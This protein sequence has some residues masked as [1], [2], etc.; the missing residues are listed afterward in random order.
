MRTLIFKTAIVKQL[1]FALLVMSPLFSQSFNSLPDWARPH[2]VATAQESAPPEADAW[3][4]LDR[5]EF[6]YTGQGEIVFQRF[7]LVRVLTDNAFD[8]GSFVIQGLG[9]KASKVKQLKGW[10][11][12]P[13][14]DVERVN[15]DDATVLTTS[16]A[17]LT[18]ASLR[19]L[20]RG[21]LVAWQSQERFNSPMGP[22]GE[23][24]ILERHPI[25]R[26][27]LELA[28]QSG[29][30]TNLRDVKVE[31]DLRG[32][33]PWVKGFE[34]VPGK[35]LAL[36]CLPAISAEEG[37]RPHPRNGLPRV[38]VR[39]TDPGLTAVPDLGQ[40]WDGMA[41]WATKHFEG[42]HNPFPALPAGTTLERLNAIRKLMRDQLVYKQFYLAPERGWV[43]EEPA[44]VGRKRYGDCKDLARFFVSAA[45][46]AGCQAFPVLCRIEHGAVEEQEPLTP[47]AFNHAIAAVKLEATLNLPAEVNTDRGRFLIVDL[48]ERYQPLGWLGSAHAGRRVL[49]CT[50]QGGIWAT[51]P[52]EATT[53]GRIQVQLKGAL[54]WQ[55]HLSGNLTVTEA[56]NALGLR[57]VAH[58]G[59]PEALRKHLL[60]NLLDLPPTARLDVISQSQPLLV[61]QPFEVV[62]RIEQ[63][64]AFRS[65]GGEGTLPGWFFPWVPGP[66]QKV[67]MPRRLPVQAHQGT[68][69]ECQAEITSALTLQPLM[70]R[71]QANTDLRNLRWEI[72]TEPRET[73]CLIRWTLSSQKKAAFFNLPDQEKGVQ[74]WKADR[75]TM[76]KLF[77]EG[78]AF[79]L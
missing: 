36:S 59:D 72:H 48:T 54:N 56:A 39:F 51:I 75:A 24:D 69:F 49:I 42:M 15:V 4:L 41:A 30:F 3:V 19:R 38:V 78:L 60:K 68:I 37:A 46:A 9:G 61:D 22:V 28:K 1:V 47:Y 14:G 62:V 58:E 52:K 5:T 25:R 57:G 67:G 77:T 34:Q 18:G 76:R 29:W 8:E 20:V 79:K 27:E 45:R 23:V 16:E 31:M 73:G 43:P 10:N 26:W 32:F 6:A 55:G 64:N 33:Q 66:I 53:E 63:P 12:R 70:P 17:V 74:A 21:S 71:F 2:V 65:Q 50:P 7:R 44:E 13:D 11:L 40:G 35:F